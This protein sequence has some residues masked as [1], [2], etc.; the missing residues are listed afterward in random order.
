MASI[1]RSE[2]RRPLRQD[3][4]IEETRHDTYRQRSK[5]REPTACPDCGAVFTS[6]RWQWTACPPEP[7]LQRCP[8]CQRIRDA[9]PAGYLHLQGP[10]LAQHHDEIRHLIDHEGQ[11]E[12]ERHPLERVMDAVASD[13]GMLVTT[14][15]T[16][17]ARRLGE[18]VHH[19]YRGALDIRYNADEQRLRVEWRR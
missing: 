16:H 3:R 6:G 19:A 11:R 1:K 18:A 13:G 15:G 2:A 10:F 4:L 5:P 8:A 12:T 14:T 17:L 7:K 9:Y